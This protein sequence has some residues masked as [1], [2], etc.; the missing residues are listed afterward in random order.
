[1]NH[2]RTLYL[3]LV[4]D[5]DVPI[6]EALFLNNPVMSTHLTIQ[7]NMSKCGYVIDSKTDRT[8]EPKTK[9]TKK[10]YPK[11]LVFDCFLDRVELLFDTNDNWRKRK[12]IT[13]NDN[14]FSMIEKTL[15]ELK[16][17]IN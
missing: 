13:K 5:C 11:Y 12:I 10:V 14:L 4:F 3:A 6:I 2:F 9:P 15:F 16:S 17:M 8:Y 7:E 1:M